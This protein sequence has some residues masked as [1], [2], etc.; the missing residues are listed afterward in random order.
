MVLD[1]INQVSEFYRENKEVID[2]LILPG[3]LALYTIGILMYK[4]RDK[5]KNERRKDSLEYYAKE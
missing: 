1:I 5:S 3:G 4:E 2:P